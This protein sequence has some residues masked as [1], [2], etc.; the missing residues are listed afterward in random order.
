MSI[1]VLGRPKVFVIIF[2]DGYN[3]DTDIIGCYS[4]RQ[5]ALKVCRDNNKDIYETYNE[6]NFDDK[7]DVCW[8][9]IDGD[10]RYYEVVP[11]PLV[12]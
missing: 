4:S 2:K 11:M 10:S 12:I 3:G 6:D 8:D 9:K 5:K 7:F 1:T